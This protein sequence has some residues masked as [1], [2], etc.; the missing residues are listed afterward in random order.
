MW[1]LAV[2]RAATRKHAV[3]LTLGVGLS[4]ATPATWLC[5]LMHWSCGGNGVTSIAF[6]IL[7]NVIIKHFKDHIDHYHWWSHLKNSPHSQL[8][9]QI[10]PGM[11]KTTLC[12]YLLSQ[13]K[14][15]SHEISQWL[16][17]DLNDACA[18][19]EHACAL[20]PSTGVHVCSLFDHTEWS[21]LP[22]GPDLGNIN[23]TAALQWCRQLFSKER[24]A[25]TARAPP[26]HF[27]QRPDSHWGSS[28]FLTVATTSPVQTPT[29]WRGKP[30]PSFI[31]EILWPHDPLERYKKIRRKRG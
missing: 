31:C 3:S 19:S 28:N 21:K 7:T 6:Q 1:N 25:M 24:A 8:Q 12:P 16:I 13:V 30:H 14:L 4:P 5:N 11:L 23:Q 22:E 9:T 17:L 15:V 2:S 29:W 27:D 10:S 18:P 26:P 20:C